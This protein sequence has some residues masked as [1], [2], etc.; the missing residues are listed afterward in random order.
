MTAVLTR[1]AVMLVFVLLIVTSAAFVA[2][3][4]LGD[5]LF[6][7]VGPLAGLD[8]PEGDAGV[9]DALDSSSSDCEIVAEARAA[10]RL[11]RPLPVRYAL[12][13]GDVIR[14]DFGW[15]FQNDQPVIEI[16]REKL[17]ETLLLLLMAQ[18]VS[19]AVAVPWG[20]AAA[21]RAD[22]LF[23]R[24]ST[25]MSFGLLSVPSF[26]LGVVMLY[27][28]ALRWQV[29]PSAYESESLPGLVFSL[30][31]PACTLGLPL[32]A[33]YQ[34]LLRTDLITTLQEDYILL[35]KAKGLPPTRIMLRHALRPSM[36][37]MVTVFGVNTGSMIAVL[38]LWSRYSASRGSDGR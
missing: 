35:A 32:A 25:V 23:D 10:H 36:F 19:F 11:D 31:L 18:T 14:G 9:S 27:L 13:L 34:R 33:V 20:V 26:A 16:I 8:C 28:L 17:P 2:L 37:S 4:T 15:S 24:A 22:R 6:N 1:R 21:Y 30:V 12:W 3:N 29:F 5:P 38:S 7:I